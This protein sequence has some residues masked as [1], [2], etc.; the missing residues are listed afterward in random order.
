VSSFT[1]IVISLVATSEETTKFRNILYEIGGATMAV[2][3]LPSNLAAIHDTESLD[4]MVALPREDLNAN[5]DHPTESL[6]SQGATKK[7]ANSMDALCSALLETYLEPKPALELRSY[8]ELESSRQKWTPHGF[9]RPAPAKMNENLMK[10]ASEITKTYEEPKHDE[11]ILK[12]VLE[13]NWS[14][15]SRESSELASE[16]EASSE[17]E[18]SNSEST[19]SEPSS[20]LSIPLPEVKL[21]KPSRKTVTVNLPE[22]ARKSSASSSVRGRNYLSGSSGRC[23]NHVC[24]NAQWNGS[25]SRYD[26]NAHWYSNWESQLNHIRFY[27]EYMEYWKNSYMNMYSKPYEDTL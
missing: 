15:E 8:E 13:K 9:H 17:S 10:Y 7:S 22:S 6:E 2:H 5:V 4:T 3:K 16:L 19:K 1:G 12:T 26:A 23:C 20:G 11:A 24:E 18:L 25:D 14:D 27:V 21:K